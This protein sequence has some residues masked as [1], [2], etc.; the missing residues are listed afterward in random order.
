MEAR[1]LRIGNLVAFYYGD[2]GLLAEKVNYNDLEFIHQNPQLYKPIPLTEEWLLKFGFDIQLVEI[3]LGEFYLKKTENH[4]EYY[5][6]N[7]VQIKYVHQLQ[8]L[9]FALTS[10][11]LEIIYM[12]PNKE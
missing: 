12:K 9:Y 11:E 3:V 8:N 4:F 7:R 2:E 5:C 10:K 6:N 1:E